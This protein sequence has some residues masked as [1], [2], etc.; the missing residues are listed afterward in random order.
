MQILIPYLHYISIMALMGSL[1]SEH[2]ILKPRLSAQQ[3]RSLAGIDF[4]Y[5][6]SAIL[7][8]VTG[9]LRWFVY[10][11]GSEFYLSNPLFHTKLTL[12]VI[13]GVLSIFPTVKFLKWRKQVKKGEDPAVEEKTVKRLL[14]YIRIELLLV[15]VMPLL[16]VMI[17]RGVGM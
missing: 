9:L 15:A 5:G 8:L 10:G 12:F 14:M 13:L 7:V 6:I 4:V 11:K 16:A 17:A 1:I 2:L 3:I